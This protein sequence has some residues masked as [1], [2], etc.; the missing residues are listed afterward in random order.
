MNKIKHLNA[1]GKG[2]F[3]YDY[4]YDTL[5]FKIKDRDY[6]MSVEFQNFAIDID[7]ENFV[8]GI[9]IFDVSKVSGLKKIIFKNLVH[10]DFKASIK[11]NVIAVRLNFVGKMRNMII[12]IFSEKQNFTQQVSAPIS[13]KYPIEDSVVTVPEIRMS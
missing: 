4:K 1:I 9:R 10:G 8:T 11:D 12:P 3:V 5:T 2:Q 7:T 6:K 13:S